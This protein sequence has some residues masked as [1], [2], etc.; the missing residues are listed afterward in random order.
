MR[1]RYPGDDL[2]KRFEIDK[3]D[4]LADRSGS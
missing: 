1:R 4:W 3:A 2:R